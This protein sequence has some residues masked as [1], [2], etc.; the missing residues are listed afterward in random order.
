MGVRRAQEMAVKAA[1]SS[2]SAQIYTLGPLVH[3]PKVLE[4]LNQL[5]IKTLDNLQNINTEEFNNCIFIIR[6]HGISPAIENKL[7]LIENAHI[8]DAT[9]PK[10]KKSQ[11]KVRELAGKGYCSFLAGEAKHAEIEGILGYAKDGVSRPPFCVT[12]G[13]AV[14][15][16]K[17]AKELYKSGKNSK[18]A[19]LGQTTISREEYREIGNEIKKYFPNLEIFDTICAATSERQKA[20]RKLFDKVEAIIIAGGKESANTRRLFK[21]AQESGKPCVLIESA[22]ELPPAFFN[23]QTIGISAG[24][25]TPDS[26][27]NEIEMI[28]S[29]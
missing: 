25:S 21:I 3:N 17:A 13:S 14:E 19:L 8:I 11:I 16:D 26:V 9:C 4:D 18:T 24:A 5:G 10:V 15:A 29:C 6:A 12:A 22:A 23:F 20:L 28:M 2:Q 7:K 27:I 1:Q